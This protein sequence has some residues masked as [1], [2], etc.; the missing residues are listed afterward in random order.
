MA[1]PLDPTAVEMVNVPT[2]VFVK[3]I[4]A[5]KN[6]NSEPLLKAALSMQTV[7][8]TTIPEQTLGR[9]A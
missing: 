5:G 6:V 9:H 4:V 7:I 8:G 3:T 2:P 1:A